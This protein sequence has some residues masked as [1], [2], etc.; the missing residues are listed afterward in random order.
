MQIIRAVAAAKPYLFTGRSCREDASWKITKINGRLKKKRSNGR[1]GDGM[2]KNSRN[3]NA[4]DDVQ[5]RM[6][7][8]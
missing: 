4:K 7:T 6:V 5:V 3:S 8:I 2:E 1:N